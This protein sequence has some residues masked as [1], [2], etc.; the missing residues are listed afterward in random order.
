MYLQGKEEPYL[1]SSGNKIVVE[2]LKH[3]QSEDALDG[4]QVLRCLSYG[5]TPVEMKFRKITGYKLIPVLI[6]AWRGK[7]LTTS[8][9]VG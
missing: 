8:Q 1:I 5:F 3:F 4:T 2:I 9:T 7:E 6:T